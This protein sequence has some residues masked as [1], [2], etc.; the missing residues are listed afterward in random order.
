MI[1]NPLYDEL[2]LSQ[3]SIECTTSSFLSFVFPVS[4]HTHS[5]FLPFKPPPS[6]SLP[7]YLLH[8]LPHLRHLPAF[9][10]SFS[11]HPS[12]D[13]STE[14]LSSSCWHKFEVYLY[15]PITDTIAQMHSYLAEGMYLMESSGTNAMAISVLQPMHV[16][17]S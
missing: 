11:I 3:Y 17:L 5:A 1:S 15:G 14:S 7:F 6:L 13:K 9:P 2:M 8:N 10:L 12:K 4:S 16:T